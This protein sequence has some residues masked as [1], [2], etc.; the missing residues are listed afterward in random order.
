MSE[1]WPYVAAFLSPVLSFLSAYAVVRINR[2]H[3]D[4]QKKH[5]G[6]DI[7]RKA[8][9]AAEETQREALRQHQATYMQDKL[10]IEQDLAAV[11]GILKEFSEMQRLSTALAT[12]TRGHAGRLDRHD[13]LLDQLN[14]RIESVNQHIV[15]LAL[16]HPKS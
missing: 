5:E 14:D 12:E 10:K 3:A 6:E 1:S 8:R 11:T 4:G 15:D 9:L 7:W 2:T 16:K 13:T